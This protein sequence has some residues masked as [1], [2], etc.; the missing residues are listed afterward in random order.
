MSVLVLSFTLL[1]CC[2]QL[3]VPD[4]S[5]F[6]VNLQ[7]VK[8]YFVSFSPMLVLHIMDTNGRD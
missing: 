3:D 1:I 6:G 5:V 8:V 2:V 4:L 7:S